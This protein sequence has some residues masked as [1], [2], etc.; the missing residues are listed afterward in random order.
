MSLYLVFYS[1]SLSLVSMSG[2]SFARRRRRRF[3]N[4]DAESD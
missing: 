1:V 4:P 2:V 3:R